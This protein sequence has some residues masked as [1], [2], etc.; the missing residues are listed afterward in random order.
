M[1]EV[2]GYIEQRANG[3]VFICEGGK[4]R[5]FEYPK[6]D[7]QDPDYHQKRDDQLIFDILVAYGPMIRREILEAAF[8]D[9]W[10]DQ[11]ISGATA[12]Q[13]TPITVKDWDGNELKV[14]ITNAVIEYMIANRFLIL[15]A[16]RD[17]FKQF[18]LLCSKGQDL[19]ALK[20]IYSEMDTSDLINQYKDNAV[21]L[22]EVYKQDQETKAFWLQMATTLGGKIISLAL[23]ALV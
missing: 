16:G 15:K 2:V 8:D 23:G 20:L 4:S 1:S 7:L 21:M 10:F 14:K 12:S 11:M 3:D 17:V 9:K 19:D 6:M 22:A 13:E 18:L 5:L